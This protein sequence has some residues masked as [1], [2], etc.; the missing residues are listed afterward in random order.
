MVKIIP[1]PPQEV[2]AVFPSIKELVLRSLEYAHGNLN[3]DDVYSHLISSQTVLWLV[4][5]EKFN[6]QSFIITDVQQYP[7]RKVI[8]ILLSAGK[9]MESWKKEATE[10]FIVWAKHIGASQIEV[11]GRKGWEKALNNLD[12]KF[13]HVV[14]VKEI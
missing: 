6:I 10:A 5:D 2:P 11:I 8:R 4:T 7:R 14:L 12:Y 9:E 1:I 3:V 13:G